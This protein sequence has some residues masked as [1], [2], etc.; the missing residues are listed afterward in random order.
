MVEVAHSKPRA[1]KKPSPIRFFHKSAPFFNL[2]LESKHPIAYKGIIYP[3]AQHVFQAMKVRIE[4]PD[5]E[6]PLTTAT[7]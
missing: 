4:Y 3:T 7:F 5:Y 6:L 2:T 1:P